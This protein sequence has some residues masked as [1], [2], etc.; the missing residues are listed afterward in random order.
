[1]L[2]GLK[3]RLPRDFYDTHRPLGPT[4]FHVS[5]LI[6]VRCEPDTQGISHSAS[7]RFIVLRK[8]A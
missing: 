3:G 4:G 1:M 8:F 5:L 7:V 6:R 2:V